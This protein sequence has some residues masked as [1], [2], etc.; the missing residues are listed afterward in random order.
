MRVTGEIS[1]EVNALA[2]IGPLS[3]LETGVRGDSMRAVHKNDRPGPPRPNRIVEC[4]EISVRC[5]LEVE[6]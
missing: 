4:G 3:L 6:S 2:G 5:S 1:L